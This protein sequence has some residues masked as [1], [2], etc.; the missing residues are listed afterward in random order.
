MKI[1]YLDVYMYADDGST[2]SNDIECVE[3]FC[4]N[5]TKAMEMLI[6]DAGSQH[7]FKLEFKNG[8]LTVEPIPLDKNG[9]RK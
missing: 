9:K 3:T 2:A 5:K 4:H 8:N 6:E 1:K 7:W